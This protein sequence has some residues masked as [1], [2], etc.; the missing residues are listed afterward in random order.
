MEKARVGYI[1]VGNIFPRYLETSRKFNILEPVACADINQ[2]AANARAAEFGIEARPVADLLAAS[3]LDVIVNLTIPPVHAQVDLQII[4]AG[5]H[6]YAEKPL[7]LTTGEAKNVLQAAD[8]AGV[9]V[10]S[11]PDTFLGGG[12]QTCRKLIDEGWIG[13]PLSAT[14]FLASR[15]PESWHPNPAFFYQTGGG[16]LYDMGPYYISTLVFLLG[17]VKRVSAS[18]RA[19]FKE[20]VVTSETRFGEVLNVEVA[21]HSAGQLEFESGAIATTILSFDVWKHSLPRI[22]I[23]GSLGTL[24]VPD[25]NTFGGP[26]QIWLHTDGEWRDVPLAYSADVQRSIGVADMMQSI[27]DDVPHRAN[28]DLAYHVLEV[29]EA[30]DK[31]SEA[32]AH[33]PIES[34]PD[35][36]ARLPIGLL[37][38]DVALR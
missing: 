3:D 7:A 23:Y 8:S 30:Y 10:G 14:A 18:T 28:G 9:R 2:A 12:L 34:R 19:S 21:T 36:P 26:V 22:E 5:K 31:S 27:R 1:G 17:A 38:G 16:P 24:R 6:V 32:G 37:P 4:E 13:E 35:Q 25:P 20:R 11:A 29:M 15:G 33:I